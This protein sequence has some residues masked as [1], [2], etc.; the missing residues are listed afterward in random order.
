MATKLRKSRIHP[1]R[2]AGNDSDGRLAQS[3]GGGLGHR[4]GEKSQRSTPPRADT[5][6]A[7]I[8]RQQSQTPPAKAKILPWVIGVE[9]EGYQ[10]P[11]GM[12]G[13]YD[14]QPPTRVQSFH[15]SQGPQRSIHPFAYK[16][17]LPFSAIAG[18]SAEVMAEQSQPRPESEVLSRGAGLRYFSRPKDATPGA[19]L[20]GGGEGGQE[21]PM[22]DLSP[23]MGTFG[24]QPS[25]D[26]LP[27]P[28][29]NAA[30]A[31]KPVP[32]LGIT[33]FLGPKAPSETIP[34]AG[35][36]PTGSYAK[37]PSEGAAAS[38]TAAPP[39]P[40]P[41]LHRS[42][43][44]FPFSPLD[45]ARKQDEAMR[46]ARAEAL[47]S[48]ESMNEY[49]RGATSPGGSKGPRGTMETM[50]SDPSFGHIFHKDGVPMS[51]H[52]STQGPPLPFPNMSSGGALGGSFYRIPFGVPMSMSLP[53]PL[54][55]SRDSAGLGIGVSLPPQLTK[56]FTPPLSRVAESPEGR[57]R[58]DDRS[59]Y[60]ETV[61]DEQEP[62]DPTVTARQVRSGGP[63]RS[64]ESAALAES[65]IQPQE[66]PSPD[67]APPLP[68]KSP[69]FDTPRPLAS[70]LAHPPQEVPA[71]TSH[72][73]TQGSVT[74][75]LPPSPRPGP[76]LSTT[77]I[78]ALGTAFTS[79]TEPG[80]NVSYASQMP[81]MGTASPGPLKQDLQAESPAE[82]VAPTNASNEQDLVKESKFHDETLC[83]L[84]DAARLNL[85]GSEAKK[86]L[87]RAAR[88]R[89]TELRAL[90]DSGQLEDVIIPV[91]SMKNRERKSKHSHGKQ[92][93]GRSSSN[94][95]TRYSSEDAN[96]PPPWA[97]EILKRLA[98]FEN[99]FAAL[100]QQSNEK[101]VSQDLAGDLIDD[102]LF[103]DVAGMTTLPANLQAVLGFPGANFTPA[104]SRTAT[105]R[106]ARISTLSPEKSNTGHQGELISWGSEVEL[107]PPEERVT[108]PKT[109]LAPVI[110]IQAPTESNVEKSQR[111]VSATQASQPRS[112]RS[113]SMA[114]DHDDD[115]PIALPDPTERDLPA[116]P[117]ESIRSHRASPALPNKVPLPPSIPSTGQAVS[118]QAFSHAVLQSRAT[119][120]PPQS[121]RIP[122]VLPP[123]VHAPSGFPFRA[124][125]GQEPPKLP[126]PVDGTDVDQRETVYRTAYEGS[127]KVPERSLARDR[128]Q[129]HD[130]S[131]LED[132]TPWDLVTQ[133]L[134]S[135][136][137]V[138]EER[139]LVSA[140][141]EISL[142]RQVD[143]FALSI[144]V[145]ITLKR[146]LRRNLS[147]TPQRVCDKLLIPPT[148]A[149]A[150][151][152][153]VHSKNF[154]AAQQMMEDLWYP[155]SFKEPPRIIIAL[156]RHRSEPDSWTAHRFDLSTG[157]LRS[158]SV[159]HEDKQLKD[160]RPFMW[161]HAIRLA[162]P[163]YKIPDPDALS[164][165]L[166]K[167]HTLPENKDDNSLEALNYA[168][169][170]FVGYRPERSTDLTKLRESVWSEVKRLLQKKRGGQ[171]VVDMHSPPHVDDL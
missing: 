133:R 5:D 132:L 102:L 154:K 6:L 62:V 118:P 80:R 9:T 76:R 45:A 106:G 23:D 158:Y 143:E 17:A 151:N 140:L 146:M 88:D 141:K 64:D 168:R 97:E 105:P 54:L 124:P 119:I 127:P 147:E 123:G 59:A 55:M 91:Q 134:Y 115:H 112:V 67:E 26:N 25:Q 42:H 120:P 94:R 142:G 14:S 46:Q 148:I 161:W 81:T 60:V 165:R 87:N 68:P 138:W 166:E 90:R 30:T 18:E 22:T 101:L 155:F 107:P 116:T 65:G 35:A 129:V 1:S 77:P 61:H 19:G 152:Q 145:M 2:Q 11:E 39:H 58:K 50:T 53:R 82:S 111:A 103:N 27:L 56:L 24:I 122:Q 79:R 85:I 96:S 139:S 66:Q 48:L 34:V 47:A 104:Q 163:Q 29:V 108:P 121:S 75:G 10:P 63:S 170:L 32:A 86:A 110:N 38:G 51:R 33:E 12:F 128:V 136:A 36:A 20:V 162:W 83:Q 57:Q 117:T 114:P 16:P 125:S 131:P 169:N 43:P 72:M 99:R 4:L 41:H 3:T 150:I 167:V 7:E 93:R 71:Q 171:L 135:W 52:I 74:P 137:L 78:P 70:A 84:L 144:F 98:A 109:P 37:A 13:P 153:A 113:P 126:T 69:T 15:E 73:A 40:T 28:Q 8:L 31:R 89:V 156:A 95:H 160:G 21:T 149:N 159:T 100:E 44:E 157:S 164:Q 92:A 49:P 130:Q